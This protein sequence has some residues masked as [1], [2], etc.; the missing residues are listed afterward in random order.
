MSLRE[1]LAKPLALEPLARGNHTHTVIFL[2]RYPQDTTEKALRAKVLSARHTKNTRSLRLEFPTVRWVYPYPK[3]TGNDGVHWTGL[4]ERDMAILELEPGRALPYITQIILQEAKRAGGL[5][6]VILGGQGETAVAAHEALCRMPELARELRD[7]PGEVKRFLQDHFGSG[8]DAIGDLRLGG[9]VGMHPNNGQLTRDERS[10]SLL[11]RFSNGG[12]EQCGLNLPWQPSVAQLNK[13]NCADTYLFS[14]ADDTRCAL[15]TLEG[16]K[17]KTNETFNKRDM[18][19][20]MT[21]FI[22]TIG[23]AAMKAA[24]NMTNIT[25]VDESANAALAQGMPYRFPSF[26]TSSDLWVKF[27]VNDTLPQE[28]PAAFSAADTTGWTRMTYGIPWQHPNATDNTTS[29]VMWQ[30][31]RDLHGNET[32][33][34]ASWG[35]QFMNPE[36][37]AQCGTNYPSDVKKPSAGPLSQCGDV[38]VPSV[39][40]RCVNV[41]AT[42]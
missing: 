37:G 39:P 33:Y 19:S 12:G 2:H 41:I 35:A 30:L 28:C 1:V 3:L 23:D 26:N 10:C 7:D 38:R 21:S 25:L 16:T 20:D 22:E 34:H 14:D 11:S 4:D 42:A 15:V 24:A 9:Y 6:K 5:E 8:G 40:V 18:A 29:A 31:S 13:T 27:F 32:L 17:L 36:A